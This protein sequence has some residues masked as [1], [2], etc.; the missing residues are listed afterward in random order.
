MRLKLSFNDIH[1][2]AS[3]SIFLAIDIRTGKVAEYCLFAYR[4]AWNIHVANFSDAVLAIAERRARPV[5]QGRVSNEK[6]ESHRFS[7]IVFQCV[8]WF[9]PN[10]ERTNKEARSPSF[11]QEKIKTVK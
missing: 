2:F 1:D 9:D 8:E 7:G 6:I 5:K 11:L 3:S 10:I 4:L